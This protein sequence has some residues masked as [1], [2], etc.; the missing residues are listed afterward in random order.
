[1]R[2]ALILAAVLGMLAGCGG[3]DGA[4]RADTPPGD[5]PKGETTEVDPG[6]DGTPAAASEMRFTVKG[7][8]CGGC[9]NLIS[10]AL[11]EVPGVVSV[12]LTYESKVAIVRVS[13]GVTPEAI[14][15]AVP[16]DYTL[17]PE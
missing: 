7:M 13:P 9:A 5:P 15:A 2:R 3:G 6:G 8:Y 14:L 1:M 12:D 11:R 10:T 16:S 17:R 4:D